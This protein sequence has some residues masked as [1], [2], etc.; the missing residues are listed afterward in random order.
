M[1]VEDVVAAEVYRA[2]YNEEL[3]RSG[4]TVE[5]P[6]SVIRGSNRPRRARDWCATNG[7]AE[8]SKINVA[9]RIIEGRRNVQ[10]L[11]TAR[12]RR[13]LIELYERVGMIFEEEAAPSSMIAPDADG[14]A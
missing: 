13:A 4:G 6:H 11:L 1:V 7:V 12:G 5:L 10:D 9:Y 8:P 3:R 2:A 14:V